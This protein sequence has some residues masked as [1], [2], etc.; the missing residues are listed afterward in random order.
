[1]PMP[2]L[3]FSSKDWP[4]SS[5]NTSSSWSISSSSI[6]SN[7]FTLMYLH[8]YLFSFDKMWTCAT[9]FWISRFDLER[10]L[11]TLSTGIV[12]V[13]TK[14]SVV[15]M[16]LCPFK[17]LS[18]SWWIDVS[19]WFV[20]L[21]TLLTNLIVSSGCALSVTLLLWQNML[22]MEE[23]I[24]AENFFGIFLWCVVSFWHCSLSCLRTFWSLCSSFS[25]C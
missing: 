12:L 25:S 18:L 14:A 23:F 21:L 8:F 17:L 20:E 11:R 13:L 15:R 4:L 10:S 19:N 3:S 22:S 1:M 7:L 9:Q 2:F 6:E 16:F 5:L 24:K